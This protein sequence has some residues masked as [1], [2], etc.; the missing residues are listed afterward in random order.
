MRHSMTA[1]RIVSPIIVLCVT[2][3]HAPNTGAATT[4]TL[5]AANNGV[6]STNCGAQT[7][8]CRSITQALANAPSGST[9]IVGPGRYGDVDG[10]GRFNSPGDEHPMRT[11][12]THPGGRPTPII[13]VVCIV[14]PV[15]IV[16][17]DGA[18]ATVIDGGASTYHV[19]EIAVQGVIFGDVKKGFTVTGGV[20]PD[21]GD[22][23]GTGLVVFA[24]STRIIGNVARSNGG[25]GFEL[26]P[27][28]EHD[29]PTQSFTNGLNGSTLATDNTAVDN[30][31]AGFAVEGGLPTNFVLLSNNTSTGN[32]QG[33]GLYGTAPHVITH[34]LVSGNGY[35]I[36]AV[37]GSFQ[38][39]HNVVTA[40]NSF[41]FSFFDKLE[42]LRGENL[43]KLNDIIG[44]GGPGVEVGRTT[45]PVNVTQNNIF[46]NGSIDGS[47]CGISVQQNGAGALN[48]YW[49]SAKGPG[50]NP[51]D[52]VGEPP[53][54][55]GTIP[56]N[57]AGLPVTKP[58]ATQ[59]FG[60]L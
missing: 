13:C 18:A 29:F 8:P 47:N 26:A 5:Y 60:I 21:N 30:A 25:A 58:F 17:M 23:G 46:G 36:G 15:H 32:G 9:V 19:V 2:A 20:R 22:A 54:C 39:T 10:D 4:G 50:V 51:A 59:P 42:I 56:N 35:G 55:N 27:G 1:F 7:Q 24:G 40:N 57:D 52:Q 6:D 34:N 14:K 45:V 49:G 11:E 33:I 41:G 12:V 44:N 31:G 3:L 48:N 38:F 37:G 16:S 53:V 28:G 43:V